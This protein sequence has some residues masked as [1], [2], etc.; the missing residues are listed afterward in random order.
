VRRRRR[1]RPE[2]IAQLQKPEG[3]AVEAAAEESG[4]EA[5]AKA[6]EPDAAAEDN[7]ADTEG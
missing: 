1:P 3:G 5:P 6:P 4:A 2:V 7:S